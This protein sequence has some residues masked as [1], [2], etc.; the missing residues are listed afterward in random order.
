MRTD[1]ILDQLSDNDSFWELIK[2]MVE[3]QHNPLGLYQSL[4]SLIDHIRFRNVE[5]D[6]GD[7]LRKEQ[8]EKDIFG[9]SGVA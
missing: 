8:Q 6:D 4:D 5:S 1:D 2:E 9:D 7:G 3:G